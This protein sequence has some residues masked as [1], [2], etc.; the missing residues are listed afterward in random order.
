MFTSDEIRLIQLAL[1]TYPQHEEFNDLQGSIRIKLNNCIGNDRLYQSISSIPREIPTSFST[2]IVVAPLGRE[3]VPAF[4]FISCPTT[5]HLDS[6]GSGFISTADNSYL[7]L[8]YNNYTGT[9][10]LYRGSRYN[11]SSRLPLSSEELEVLLA[12]L[13]YHTL[14]RRGILNSGLKPAEEDSETP[15]NETEAAEREIR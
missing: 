9:A 12:F 6:L 3:Q 7:Q 13:M 8:I 5:L 15:E 14:N 1:D 10:V 4:K 11:R 2:P